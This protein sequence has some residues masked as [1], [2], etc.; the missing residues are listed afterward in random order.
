MGN[1][2]HRSFPMTTKT[3]QV[4]IGKEGFMLLIYRFVDSFPLFCFALDFI[5]SLLIL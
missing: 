4:T 3:P 1:P 2:V 5:Y